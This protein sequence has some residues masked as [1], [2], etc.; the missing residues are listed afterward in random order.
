MI[1]LFVV[2]AVGNLALFALGYYWLGLPA[3]STGNVVLSVVL[4]VLM[5]ALAAYLLAL[6]FNRDARSAIGSIPALLIWL[7]LIAPVA[8]A[9]AILLSYTAG[10]D[11]WINSALTF[12]TRIP[13]QLKYIS[14]GVLL[15]VLAIVALRV[16][17]PVAVRAAAHGADGLRDWRPVPLTLGYFLAAAAWL[18][19][20]LWMPWKLFW[21]IPTLS[22]FEGQ[23]ASLVLRAGLTFVL[24]VGAWLIFAGY[25]RTKTLT[26]ER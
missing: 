4:V 17:L 5:M 8:Y 18:F 2:D 9:F 16:L 6:A 20:G 25:C 13:V 7:G 12:A 1:R 3:S 22:S 23:M 11:N 15:L 24:Y 10:I 26:P 19:A 14:S 21:W